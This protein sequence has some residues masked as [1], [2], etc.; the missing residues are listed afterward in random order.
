MTRAVGSS[1]AWAVRWRRAV[2]SLFSRQKLR[3]LVSSEN[4]KDLEELAGLADR[5]AFRPV[6]DRVFPLADAAKAMD[7][8]AAGHARGKVVVVP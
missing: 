4:A 6:L 1:A 8:L 3:G 7:H 2:Q 5:G